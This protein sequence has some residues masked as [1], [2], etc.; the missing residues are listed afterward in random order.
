MIVF[1]QQRRLTSTSPLR[2]SLTFW[3]RLMPRCTA[4]RTMATISKSTP[5]IVRTAKDP[6]QQGLH[7]V[8][9]S[10]VEQVNSSVRL[11]QLEFPSTGVGQSILCLVPSFWSHD[12]S[13]KCLSVIAQDHS[14]SI[15]NRIAHMLSVPGRQH[16]G[17]LQLSRSMHKTR[18]QHFPLPTP[19][20]KFNT[21][22]LQPPSRPMAR[23]LHSL[24]F[25]SR[26]L[27]HH[28]RP[29]T[30]GEK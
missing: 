7:R 27:H 28:L 13:T 4:R 29:S 10:K 9:V 19:A 30:H 6:R 23:R 18:N 22:Q 25:P 3:H 11:I 17:S 2:I 24:H 26:G 14:T 12:F 16:Y 1:T 20:Y 21:V 15:E 8:T 5:H